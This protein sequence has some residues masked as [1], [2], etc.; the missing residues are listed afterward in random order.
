MSQTTHRTLEP[1]PADVRGSE[2][3]RAVI[4]VEIEKGDAPCV[5]AWATDLSETGLFLQTTMAL[6][7][8]D[9]VTLRFVLQGA[10]VIIGG[11]KV[12]RTRPFEPINV[13]GEMPGAAVEFVEVSALDK[14]RLRRFIR[15]S[16]PGDA[17]LNVDDTLPPTLMAHD[18][19]NTPVEATLP[20]H[21]AAKQMK[22]E[23]LAS[24][25]AKV[26]H[27]ASGDDITPRS[28]ARFA[29]IVTSIPPMA[30]IEDDGGNDDSDNGNDIVRT[31]TVPPLPSAAAAN[32]STLESLRPLT[33]PPLV[34]DSANDVGAFSE[35]ESASEAA[36]TDSLFAALDAELSLDALEGR[37]PETAE[38]PSSVDAFAHD[39]EER[40]TEDG[41][42]S[43]KAA[44]STPPRGSDVFEID[45]DITPTE[46]T[47]PPLDVIDYSRAKSWTYVFVARAT[48]LPDVNTVPPRD[49][50]PSLTPRNV[51][52]DLPDVRLNTET[53]PGGPADERL[54]FESELPLMPAPN[55]E[56]TRPEIP[57]QKPRPA[58]DLDNTAK[59]HRTDVASDQQ[60]NSAHASS[61]A[62]ALLAA[63]EGMTV[64]G[65]WYAGADELVERMADG[66]SLPPGVVFDDGD[67]SHV[68]SLP[69]ESDAFEHEEEMSAEME[70]DSDFT[71][72]N[73]R[74]ADHLFKDDP[75]AGRW[76]SEPAIANHNPSLGEV[77]PSVLG[78]VN[79]SES[80]VAFAD[81]LWVAEQNEGPLGHSDLTETASARNRR[82]DALVNEIFGDDSSGDLSAFD[83]G[84]FA[85]SDDDSSGAF[86]LGEV[87]SDGIDVP[88]DLDRSFNS[89]EASIFTP[90]SAMEMTG[91]IRQRQRA[92]LR[93]AAIGAIAIGATALGVGL[94]FVGDSSEDPAAVVTAGAP[95]TSTTD[96]AVAAVASVAEV[97]ED[98]AGASATPQPVKAAPKNEPKATG[99]AATEPARATLASAPKAAPAPKAA[100]ATSAAAPSP[101]TTATAA[102]PKIERG[103]V[104]V[105]LE[106][107]RVVKSFALQNPPRLVVDLEGATLPK[108]RQF[109]IGDK[110]VAKLRFGRPDDKHVRFVVELDR[111]SAPRD[112]SVLKRQN[113]L[114]VAWK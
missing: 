77:T 1:Q 14:A 4:E 71:P 32:P 94:A 26:N 112:L 64:S 72:L 81:R 35:S 39:F 85:L 47:L 110:G 44:F 99:H 16:L 58:T 42:F 83:D 62:P 114:A 92:P 20:L 67:F 50:G 95:A 13:T 25:I 27:V 45:D 3:V 9:I 19:E 66:R 7:V 54:A 86:T 79:L 102:Q 51:P 70:N 73:N 56:A 29:E 37:T 21:L 69:P 90:A 74:T 60:G 106:G 109:E 76:T 104:T 68:D 82:S 28:V 113:S 103:R 80:E 52:T 88:T 34:G 105:A 36:D 78:D 91:R 43:E 89:D 11:A 6:R 2:R 10:K 23:R 84:R 17:G 75:D 40:A 38:R 100:E 24:R 41:A 111:T 108:T 59:V 49:V 98:L 15:E 30:P 63:D 18:D 22:D 12:T 57:S 31:W 101:T 93:A 107:G 55:L 33:L 8:D 53:L 61:G 96:E 5:H 65:L 97:E 46:E 48:P 87:S